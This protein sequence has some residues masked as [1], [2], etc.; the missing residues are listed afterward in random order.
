[1]LRVLF[2]GLLLAA[3]GC[4][5][6]SSRADTTPTKEE[7][8]APGVVRVKTASVAFLETKEWKDEP[9]PVHF[10][11]PARVVFRDGALAN[12]GT[13]V[14]GRVSQVH[15]S[16]GQKVERNEPLFTVKSPD[17]ASARA[18]LTATR[19]ALEAARTNAERAGRMVER[20]VGSQREKLD[21]DLR[22][23]ELE[24]ELARARTTVSFVGGG[25]GADVVVRSPIAGTV[26]V[27]DATVGASVTADGATLIGVGDPA[28][29]WVEAD[30]F[31]RDLPAL[32]LGQSAQVVLPSNPTPLSGKVQSIGAVLRTD[33]R[34]APVRVA[35]DEPSTELRPGMFGS[36]EIRAMSKVGL[37]PTTAVLI[38]DG[39]E[40]VVFVKRDQ[41]TFQRRAVQVGSTHSGSVQVLSGLEVGEHV[42]VRG[43]L[44]LDGALDQVL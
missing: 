25:G 35:L 1:M 24:A 20:G 21:A 22:V 29:I 42:V 34:S 10:R 16:L 6:S 19:A 31:E 12:V 26:V 38:R 8:V 15:V 14:P 23:A 33:L 32:S 4:S 39:R 3:P 30:V 13:P 9:A 5:S 2:A 28:D 17:A 27:R 44:L 43:A 41:A 40:M 36:V 37:L 18:S 7:P 11:L